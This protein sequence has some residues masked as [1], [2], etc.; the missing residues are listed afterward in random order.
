[1]PK[2]P[3]RPL[4]RRYPAPDLQHHPELRRVHPDLQPECRHCPGCAGIYALN[5]DHWYVDRS[6]RPWADRYYLPFCRRCRIAAQSHRRLDPAK[7]VAERQQ[8]HQTNRRKREQLNAITSAGQSLHDHEVRTAQRLK[9]DRERKDREDRHALVRRQH[10]RMAG[11]YS[12]SRDWVKLK[13]R[14]ESEAALRKRLNPPSDRG[15]PPAVGTTED[16]GARL[17]AIRASHIQAESERSH[18]VHE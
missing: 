8:A 2:F 11:G 4:S 1:M 3:P 7:A 14:R 5:S 15:R 16:W 13:I 18:K 10:V 9:N 17:E 6:R 12:E